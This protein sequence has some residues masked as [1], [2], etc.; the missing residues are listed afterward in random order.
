M[1]SQPND[2]TVS[3]VYATNDMKVIKNYLLRVKYHIATVY[4]DTLSLAL[5]TSDMETKQKLLELREF[6]RETFVM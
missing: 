4:K 6:I 3:D 5:E 2:I 1:N